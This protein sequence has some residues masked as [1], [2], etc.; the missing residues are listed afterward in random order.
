MKYLILC[1][2]PSVAS[3]IFQALNQNSKGKRNEGYYHCYY[4]NEEYLITYCFGHLYM[5]SLFDNDKWDFNSLPL[6][7]SNWKIKPFEDK[8]RQ[9]NIIHKLLNDTDNIIIS[10]DAGREG[11]LIARE[12][13]ESYNQN[14]YNSK[15]IFRLWTSKALSS[16]VVQNIFSNKIIKEYSTYNNLYYQALARQR[17]DWLIGIN[18][19][20]GYTTKNNSG[21][22]SIGRVQTPVLSVI[23]KRTIDFKNYIP[24][25]K[26]SI[27]F[28]SKDFILHTN[29]IFDNKDEA[30]QTLQNFSQF[31][32]LKI[33]D[34]LLSENINVKCP[35]LFSLT[36][37]QKKANTLYGFTAQKT[38]DILQILYEKYKLISYPRSDS[39]YL[40]NSNIDD[41]KKIISK[42][43][44]PQY[45]NQI[46]SFKESVFN[47]EKLTDHHAIICL[48]PLNDID[49]PKDEKL[50]Y[51]LILNQMLN[52][53]K[54]DFIYKKLF[55]SGI[56]NDTLFSNTLF[57]K[58][59]DGWKNN[60]VN[61]DDEDDS[62][63]YLLNIPNINKDSF[64]FGSFVIRE[65]SSKPPR[66]FTDS[67]I[68]SF[69]DKYFLGTPA[70]RADIIEKLINRSYI[71]RENKKL[72]STNKGIELINTLEQTSSTLLDVKYT[73]NFEK[74]ISTIDNKNQLNTFENDIKN[75]VISEIN[76]IKN[77]T[78]SPTL[79]KKQTDFLKSLTKNIKSDI[80]INTINKDNFNN[81]IE[82]LKKENQVLCKCGNPM[83][84]GPKSYFC[85]NCNIYIYKTFLNKKLSKNQIQDILFGKKLLIKGFISK[86]GK[87]FDGYLSLGNDNKV[88]LTFK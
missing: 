56:Q 10:T 31:D 45:V 72:I 30:L 61:E 25:S 2:K 76:L 5:L 43:G 70:T 67:T 82:S 88:E 41:Y 77:N 16:D 64:V 51:N 29:L 22:I 14:I 40:S 63:I 78:V 52:F 15:K 37:L 33:N 34:V 55:V 87:T 32:K 47:D 59:S 24:S 75:F 74:I 6:F 46:D 38:L 36:D 13:L 66:L 17:A 86:S 23:V 3:D 49:L 35:L 54:G 7:P 53:F 71:I 57:I 18:L 81:I 65:I 1:E 19:T 85:S 21:V 69:M 68:L 83:K 42:L 27:S 12:V 79:T 84:E 26:F 48:N 20:R 58:I 60:T 73:S 9:I 8:K 50:I 80:D 28:E 4:N 11:E 39:N 44:F 62:K